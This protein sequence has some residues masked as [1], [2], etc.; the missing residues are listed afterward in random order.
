MRT[1]TLLPFHPKRDKAGN[2]NISTDIT[3]FNG[4]TE[5]SNNYEDNKDVSTP[6][7]GHISNNDTHITNGNTGITNGNTH[8]TNGNTHITNGNTGI[9]I[10]KSTL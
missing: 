6:M 3:Y 8:I 7:T 9:A 1:H 4:N 2:D 5:I 10:D